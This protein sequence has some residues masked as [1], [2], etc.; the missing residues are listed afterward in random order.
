MGH[1]AVSALVA[2]IN[3]TPAP[4]TE[5]LFHPELIVR[6]STG[7]APVADLGR[8]D[9][10]GPRRTLT[11]PTRAP[12]ATLRAGNGASPCLTPPEVRHAR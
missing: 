1:A 9:R 12:R 2:E 4:R 3:G 5:L 7:A 10:R 6:G 11:G 8:C